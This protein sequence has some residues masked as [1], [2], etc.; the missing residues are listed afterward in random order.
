MQARRIER[1]ASLIRTILAEAIQTRLNDPRI[2]AITSIT[3]VEI[4][5]D[6]SVARVYVSV[7]ASDAGRRTCLRAL[8][9]S[10]KHLRWMLGGEL[11]LRKTPTLDFRLDESLR[12]GFETVQI[13]ERAM[14]ALDDEPEEEELDNGDQTSAAFDQDDDQASALNECDGP[15]ENQ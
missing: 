4:A 3:R 5:A 8:Q 13:I 2:P 12:H 9:S 1:V 6:F 14:E 10:A 15:R 11:S 7:M